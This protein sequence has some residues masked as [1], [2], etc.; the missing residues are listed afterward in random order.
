MSNTKTRKE[1][2]DKK[3]EAKAEGAKPVITVSAIAK[4]FNIDP[5]KLRAKMRSKGAMS[6]NGGRYELEPNSDAHKLVL[7]LAE[8][9]A[10]A[11]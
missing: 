6:A 2:A 7:E 9:L 3:K 1:K 4:E 11:K 8:S 10:P 5:K